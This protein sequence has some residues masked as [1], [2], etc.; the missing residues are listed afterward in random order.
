LLKGWKKSQYNS[1][2]LEALEVA[3]SIQGENPKKIKNPK[4]HEY[5][6]T[7][8]PEERHKGI[9]KSQRYGKEIPIF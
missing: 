7:S 4:R 9:E 3:P 5:K 1:L 8:E 2:L 6:G